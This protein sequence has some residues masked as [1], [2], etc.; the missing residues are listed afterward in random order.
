MKS[1]HVKKSVA[2]PASLAV[3]K[4]ATAAKFA[5]CATRRN[6]AM[7]RKIAAAARSAS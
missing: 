4:H 2:M 5:M 7:T 6:V 1:V 3:M